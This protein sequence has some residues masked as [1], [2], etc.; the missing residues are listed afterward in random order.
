MD[1]KLTPM[2]KQYMDIKKKYSQEILSQTLKGITRDAE[3][4]WRACY[5]IELEDGEEITRSRIQDMTGYSLN[6]I[7]KHIKPLLDRGYLAMKQGGQGQRYLY[8]LTDKDP[9]SESMDQIRL[10]ISQA[11]VRNLE[12]FATSQDFA[13]GG[14]EVSQT[15]EKPQLRNFARGEGGGDE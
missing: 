11:E 10:D 9:D 6:T 3:K 14:C 7:K 12:E 8:K 13:N 5:K 15:P 2:M 1:S 4:I